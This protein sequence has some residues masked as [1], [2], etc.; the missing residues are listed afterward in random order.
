MTVQMLTEFGEEVKVPEPPPLDDESNFPTLGGG[1]GA[2][3]SGG[4]GVGAGDGLRL[5][6]AAGPSPPSPPEIEFRS[7][8]IS[9]GRSNM[10][11]ASPVASSAGAASGGR[12]STEEWSENNAGN[13]N[14]ADRLRTASVPPS[15]AGAGGGGRGGGVQVGYGA[16]NFAGRGGAGGG[17]AAAAAQPWV[18]TG[19]AVNRTYTVTR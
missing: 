6:E 17:R 11:M 14:F 1:G 4:G 13:G 3:G 8:T 16:G 5:A 10:R 9:G 15:V 18:E 19:E 2:R 12:V 7:F